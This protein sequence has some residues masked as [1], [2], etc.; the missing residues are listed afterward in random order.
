MQQSLNLTQQNLNLSIV[1]WVLSLTINSSCFP[2]CACNKK[3]D[4]SMNTGFDWGKR[5]WSREFL[6][7]Y[8]SPEVPGLKIHRGTPQLRFCWVLL[9]GANQSEII[10]PNSTH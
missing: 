8:N 7:D 6:E 4:T 9:S 2:R 10:K 5:I 1:D 3:K